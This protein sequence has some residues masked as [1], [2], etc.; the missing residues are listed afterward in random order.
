AGGSTAIRS[1]AWE[2]LGRRGGGRRFVL[3]SKFDFSRFVLFT[4][5]PRKILGVIERKIKDVTD[6]Q[7]RAGT[8]NPIEDPDVDRLPTHCFN[9]CQENVPSIKDWN[10]QQ[11]YQGEV[12]VE[13]HAEPDRHPPA[14]VAFKQDVVNAQNPQ[15]AGEM[16]RL[17]VRFARKERAKRADHGI[18]AES[19]LLKRRGI[20]EAHFARIIPFHPDPRH[21]L[22]G[23]GDFRFQRHFINLIPSLSFKR[24]RFVRMLLDVFTQVCRVNQLRAVD[25]EDEIVWLQSGPFG[26]AAVHYFADHRRERRLNSDLSQTFAFPRF[27]LLFDGN[28]S[29]LQDFL[30]PLDFDADGLAFAAPN[31]PGHTVAHA[32]KPHDSMTIHLQNF[33]SPQQTYLFC[34]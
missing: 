26:R 13:Q 23:N 14:L 20:N 4:L 32:G 22:A 11:V 27:R 1:S 25:S 24:Q 15:R 28:G 31:A 33:I 7:N 9:Q 30:G 10:G 17:D 18:N 19:D 29:E 8:L 12:D 16:L 5:S 34:W 3:G 2:S 21:Q 6:D